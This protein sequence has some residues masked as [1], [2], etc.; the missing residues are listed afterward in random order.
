MVNIVKSV[1][2]LVPSVRLLHLVDIEPTLGACIR[3][4]FALEV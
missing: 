3:I 2:F 4:S 1:V